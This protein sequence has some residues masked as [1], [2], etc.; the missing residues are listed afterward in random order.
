MPSLA[1]EGNPKEDKIVIASGDVLS[2]ATLDFNFLSLG[3]V[4][5]VVPHVPST[6]NSNLFIESSTCNDVF[7]WPGEQQGIPAWT[8]RDYYNEIGGS[9]TITRDRSLELRINSTPTCWGVMW[10]KVSALATLP[11]N[12]AAGSEIDWT[13]R[14]NGLIEGT[15]RAGI[16]IWVDDATTHLVAKLYALVI[17][18]DLS[19]MRMMKW[20][21]A[22]LIDKT[23]GTVLG[24]ISNLPAVNDE[25]LLQMNQFPA[26]IGASFNG[27]TA[28]WS[29]SSGVAISSVTSLFDE[30]PSLANKQTIRHRRCGVGFISIGGTTSGRLAFTHSPFEPTRADPSLLVTSDG[31]AA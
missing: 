5:G 26:N 10:Q 27:I 16:C 9:R 15:P 29:N 3:V 25:L 14:F 11:T 24:T 18:Y 20:D 8:L 13:I 2:T 19:V 22:S 23:K 21:D 12:K 4:P 7:S 1:H 17:D 6:A 30:T 28:Q 31:E